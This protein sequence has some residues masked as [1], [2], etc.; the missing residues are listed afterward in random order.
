[1]SSGRVGPAGAAR[2]L[3][4]IATAVSFLVV[5]QNFGL[6]LLPDRRV[7]LAPG[8]IRPLPGPPTHAYA[9][10]FD[11][12]E[13]DRWPSARSRVRFFEDGRAYPVRLH[14]SDEVALV[15]GARFS[16]EP[17]RIVFSSTDNTDPRTNGR[18]YDLASPL[19]YHA[20]MGGAAMAA[21]LGCV[22]AWHLA[23]RRCAG[24]AARPAAGACRWRWHLAG[25]TALFALGLYCCTGTL[26]PYAITTAPVIAHSTGYAYNPDHVHF[27]ALFDLVDGRDRA[28][29]GGAIMARRILFPA[30]AWPLMRALGFELGGTLASLAL[31]VVGFVAAAAV[32]RRRVGDRGAAAAAWLMALYPGAAYWAGL[33]YAYAVIFPASLLLMLGLLR[34]AE[35]SGPGRLAVVSLLMGLCYLGYDLAVI[36]VPATLLVLCWRRRFAAAVGSAALQLAPLA[37]WLYALSHGLRQPLANDNS[38]IYARV[39][40]GALHSP[41]AA[42]WGRQVAQAAGVGCDIFF[43]SNFI[44]IP[45]LFLLA[46]ALNPLTS[47]V[48]FHAAEVA[49]LASGLALFAV[50][51]LAPAEPGGW[52]MR[53]TWIS[54]IYQ[55]VFPALLVFVARWWQGLPADPRGL[56]WLAAS[57]VVATLGCDALVVFGPILGDPFHVSGDAF[58]R[59]YDHTDAHFLYRS[60]LDSLGRSPLG[61]AGRA[62]IPGEKD[63]WDPRVAQL[64]VAVRALGNVRSAIAQNQIALKAVQADFRRVG[65]DLADARLKLYTRQVERRVGGGEITAEQA[66]RE[67]KTAEDFIGPS[68]RAVP[69]A[70]PRRPDAGE[71]GS[72]QA[73]DSIGAVQA[74]IAADSEVLKATEQE[75]L[76]TQGELTAALSELARA[77]EELGRSGEPGK[78]P[79]SR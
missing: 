10:D 36:Y 19:L 55:P 63:E 20:W 71:P 51:N 13:P 5:L 60:N 58:Y 16:H 8:Q 12:S 34:L 78:V 56:R 2:W 26:A 29:W 46:V 38:G 66:R 1:M 42:A 41:G 17:G 62:A 24:A 14:R 74:A 3:L 64:R 27:R 73:P 28:A 11:G 49:V 52:E 76:W 54:R 7:H 50:L 57:A 15:G 40:W 35:P 4:S 79:A 65:R 22:A 25:S 23:T 18:S 68:L 69:D 44:F 70:P 9:F 6:D 53:G 61:F 72:A 37:A 21:F 30:L 47:R 31:N 48:R 45:A 77:R 32:L 59:F 43:A 39:L 67:A 33:P 75:I